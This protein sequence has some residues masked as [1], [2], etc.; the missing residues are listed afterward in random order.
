M[1]GL[2]FRNYVMDEL[3]FKNNSKFHITTDEIELDVNFASKINVH[4]NAA[5][6][7]LKAYLDEDE[8]FPFAFS[9]KIVGFF[10]YNE[11]EAENIEFQELLKTNAIAILFSYLRAL[12]SDIT[13]KSNVYPNYNIPVM[14]ISHMLIEEGLIEVIHE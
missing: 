13:G 6:V 9:A 2:I 10:E 4:D 7:S 14:N 1:T 5:V 8:Q 11:V 3:S 12:V